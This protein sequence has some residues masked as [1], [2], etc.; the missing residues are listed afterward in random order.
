MHTLSSKSAPG[1]GP[2]A[3]TAEQQR[4]RLAE[5]I[6]LSVHEVISW[7]CLVMATKGALWAL[8]A[9][10]LGVIFLA[11]TV[12]M[13]KQNLVPSAIFGGSVTVVLFLMGMRLISKSVQMYADRLSDIAVCPTGLR[14]HKG[15]QESLALWSEIAAVDVA[16]D[17]PQTGMT[18]LVGAAQA[19]SAKASINLVTIK[20]HSGESLVL[21]A[22]TLSDIERFAN[23][24]KDRHVLSIQKGNQ[25][26]G[27][28]ASFL[29]R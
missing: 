1:R 23:T 26:K 28:R 22:A 10:S 8:L 24:V 17:V 19:W 4:A 14:W 21:R 9:L 16:W 27:S 13:V 6:S 2:D 12:A 25:V 7:K 15:E 3:A 29:P 11:A 18:G 20:T 5:E